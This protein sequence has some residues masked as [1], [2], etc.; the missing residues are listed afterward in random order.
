[1]AAVEDAGPFRVLSEW[2]VFAGRVLFCSFRDIVLRMRHTRVVLRQV[3]DVAVG[4]GATVIGG[5]LVFVVFTMAF[6]VGATVG[7]QG[8]QGLSAIGAQSYV[9]LVGSFANVR[10]I[11]PIIAATA[12]AA[13]VGSA[14]TAELGAMRVSDEIDALEVMGVNAFTYLVCTRVVAALVALV[15]IYLIALFSSFF[16]TRLMCTELFGMAPGDYDHYFSLYLPV[17][18]VIYS[19]TKVAVFA[20]TVVTIHCYYGFNATGG[21]VGVGVAAGRAIRLSIVAVVLLNLL[22]SYLFWGQGGT[23]RF[24]G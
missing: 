9:G 15:P 14:F 10:E 23:I 1:M 6:F 8:Y 19:V 20:F 3:S 16:A 13:Q 4:V 21:P 11:T 18:D 2:P 7:L 24:T 5:G 17:T 22:L 12:L